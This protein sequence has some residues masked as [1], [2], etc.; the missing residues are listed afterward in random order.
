MM[1]L[2]SKVSVITGAAG[3]IG[4]ALATRLGDAGMRLVLVDR[5]PEVLAVAGSIPGAEGHVMDVTDAEAQ[6]EL[7]EHVR[8]SH[9]GV[10]LVIANA[11]INVH[12]LFLDQSFEDIERIV[13][14]NLLGVLYLVRALG[15]D[16]RSGGHVVLVSSLAGRV[17]FPYQTTYCATKFGVRG[18]GAA[19]HPELSARGVGVTTVMPGTVA[20]RLLQTASSYDRGAS[21]RMADLMLR[22]GLSPE[23]VAARIVDAVRRG[24]REVLI[25]W[26]ARLATGLF[27]RGVL[28]PLLGAATRARAARTTRE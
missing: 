22:Y 24:E 13:R 27:D 19:L 9:G 7:A 14:V 21:A 2:A 12:G 8:R 1:D 6:R 16:V 15:P 5:D 3:G 10:D 28:G 26:D 11:G 25:G 23:K 18:F 17:P 20:T 4:A